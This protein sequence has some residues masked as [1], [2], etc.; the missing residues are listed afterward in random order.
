MIYTI[1]E[2][3]ESEK[4]KACVKACK[5]VLKDN[6]SDEAKEKEIAYIALNFG[7]EELDYYDF[8][9]MIPRDLADYYSAS[10]KD[11][12]VEPSFWLRTDISDYVKAKRRMI[13]R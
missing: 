11:R 10:Y 4:G 8:K 5:A 3:M 13:Q 12:K 2:K 9:K 7:F 6:I 1:A